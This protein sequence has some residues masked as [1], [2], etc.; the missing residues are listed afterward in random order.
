MNR[1]ICLIIS[2]TLRAIQNRDD[3]PVIGQCP[4]TSLL[5]SSESRLRAHGF[6]QIT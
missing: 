3:Q 4:N 6:P 5:F 1:S 2:L